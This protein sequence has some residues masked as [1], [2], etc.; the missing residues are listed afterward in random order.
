MTDPRD[1]GVQ[2]EP[3][4]HR[5][6]EVI[7]TNTGGGGSGAGMILAAVILVLG[8]IFAIW[9][10]NNSGAGDSIPSEI[11]VNVSTATTN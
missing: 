7:V 4:V 3:E 2:R 9:Y 11:D 6:R 1:P 8:V 10:F 5:D